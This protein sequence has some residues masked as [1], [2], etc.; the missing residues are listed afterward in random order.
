M[1]R[2]F[3]RLA[4]RRTILRKHTTKMVV[5]QSPTTVVVAAPTARQRVGINKTQESEGNE[6]KRR[7]QPKHRICIATEVV[8]V[9]W[10]WRTLQARSFRQSTTVTLVNSRG[11]ENM[12]AKSVTCGF[13][14]ALH[15][16]LK[17]S[18]VIMDP[19][20]AS[21]RTIGH[22]FLS[23]CSDLQAVDL[24]QLCNVVTV[25]KAFLSGCTDLQAVDLS[26]LSTVV[27]IFDEFLAGCTNLRSVDLKPLYNVKSVG[28]RFLYGCSS[29]KS[30]DLSPLSKLQSVGEGFLDGC[31]GIREVFRRT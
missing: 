1:K 8:D 10:T 21:L 7:P 13:P 20:M 3:V 27:T 16:L 14:C 22:G 5:E 6:V 23:G 12:P 2:V 4:Q 19:S 29:L 18:K 25:R 28:L 31:C 26:S 30:V 11:L 17:P 15:K 9:G 24:S